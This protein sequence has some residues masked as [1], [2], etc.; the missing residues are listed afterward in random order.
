MF[1]EFEACLETHNKIASLTLSFT[2]AP[3]AP[4]TLSLLVL[5]WI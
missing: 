2:Y 3:P 4:P 5:S 1:E